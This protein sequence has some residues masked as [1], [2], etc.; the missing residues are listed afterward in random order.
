MSLQ[1]QKGFTLIE[2]M[3]VIAIIGILAA[4]ALPAY[5]TYAKK[6]KFSEVVMATTAV[7]SAVDLCYQTTGQLQ[8]CAASNTVA[9]AATNAGVG[10]HVDN[11][12]VVGGD[13]LSEATAFRVEATGASP[14][15]TL[16]YILLATDIPN[17]E[18]K[19]PSGALTW[20]IDPL[21]TCIKPGL[22]DAPAV[23]ADTT[24][25]SG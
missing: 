3:I 16:T 1:Q 18:T 19:L 22:C 13:G 10:K 12:K 5:Q 2:L 24:G 20:T 6:A 7:K 15:D 8:Q 9:N 21:S 25:T 23:E 14:V 11:V 17:S 4:L